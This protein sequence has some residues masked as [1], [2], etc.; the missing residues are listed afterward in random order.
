MSTI[1]STPVH[2]VLAGLESVGK[3][4]LFRG[5]T[6]QALGDETNV[7]GSTVVCRKCRLQDCQCEVVDTPG[8]RVESDAESTRL[9]VEA[10]GHADVVLLVVRATHLKRELDLLLKEL[11]L[12]GR[13]AALAVTF[14]DKTSADVEGL[15]GR[16]TQVL[17]I[18]VVVVNA[19]ALE[20]ED[21]QA[22]LKAVDAA[23]PVTMPGQ[24]TVAMPIVAP[25]VNPPTTWFEHPGVGP[26][27]AALSVLIL[28]GFPVYAAYWFSGWAQPLVDEALVTPLRSALSWLPAWWRGVLTG[29]YG[30]LTLGWY[31]FLWA[32]PVVVLTGI[33]VA[34]AEETGV[35]DRVTAALDP[36]LRRIGLE[37]RDLVPVLSGFGC[38]VV[39]VL[40]SRACG[41]CSRKSCM[42]MI[43]FGSACS[44]QIGASL[45]LFSAAGHPALFMPYL[46]ALCIVGAVHTRF[47]HG[48]LHGSAVRGLMER[49]FLQPPRWRAV[50]WR[51][52]AVCGQFLMQ[53]MPVFLLVCVA[54]ACLDQLGVLPKLAQ[55]LEPVTRSLGL[56]GEVAPAL[57]FSVIRKDGML[58]LNAESGSLIQSMSPGQVFLAVWLMSTLTACVV[59][60]WT[61]RKEL[62]WRT[63]GRL[64]W[65]QAAT[66]VLSTVVL[67]W[68]VS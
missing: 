11:K 42:A 6:R 4:A 12:K 68:L 15:A 54:A 48:G 45:S 19:R 56:P 66:S 37:G 46:A 30:V 9:A 49:S 32:F 64:L 23:A 8:I 5:L 36:W 51:L 62:G 13:R 60:L 2:V 50:Q 61:I 14:R 38:N 44:Y 35:K 7:R 10:M 16:I 63:A 21:R 41:A 34:L 67:A 40:Q 26:W 43:S 53:A 24:W 3:S 52:R 1:A 39:A 33:F 59:T 28:F 57:I 17:N 27:L 31:S 58:A 20:A 47:W 18:P 65:R 29:G 22:I 25:N 55:G